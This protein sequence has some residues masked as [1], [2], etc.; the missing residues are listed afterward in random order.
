MNAKVEDIQQENTLGPAEYAPGQ[1]ITATLYKKG[2]QIRVV[3]GIYVRNSENQLVFIAQSQFLWMTPSVLEE[4]L[5][6]LKRYRTFK[7]K[8]TVTS[9]EEVPGAK[10]ATMTIDIPATD[11]P[12]TSAT[13]GTSS[14]TSA[15]APLPADSARKM[16]ADVENS[17]LV[18]VD[19]DEKS[20]IV[21]GGRLNAK[22]LNKLL[23]QL[24][25]RLPF[26][27]KQ[28]PMHAPYIQ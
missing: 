1:G 10:P 5:Q 20:V 9:K 24:S 12:S 17:E 27:F 6:E 13:A 25:E 18:L 11:K 14:T 26:V 15:S 2:T 19:K 16:A 28:Y 22:T 7:G 4:L 21:T 23:Q 8:V 3:N